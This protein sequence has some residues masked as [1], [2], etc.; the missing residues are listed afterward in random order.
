M[1]TFNQTVANHANICR[2]PHNPIRGVVSMAELHFHAVRVV[3]LSMVTSKKLASDVYRKQDQ[4]MV[5]I[6]GI[7]VIAAIGVAASVP[8]LVRLWLSMF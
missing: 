7:I 3:A 6:G 2:L 4:R 5:R 1:G 8:F